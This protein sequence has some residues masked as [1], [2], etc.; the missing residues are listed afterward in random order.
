MLNRMFERGPLHGVTK[1][2][3]PDVPATHW[4][5]QDIEEAATAH[6]YIIDQEKQ[7]VIA[8]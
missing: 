4:A 6:S 8:Q 1:P 7:E 5:F 2:S 3:F